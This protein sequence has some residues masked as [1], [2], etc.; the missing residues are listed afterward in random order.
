MGLIPTLN[1]WNS[2]CDCKAHG[3]TIWLYIVQNCSTEPNLAKYLRF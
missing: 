1:K 2:Q 3:L